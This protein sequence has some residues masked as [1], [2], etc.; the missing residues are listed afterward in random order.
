[1]SLTSGLLCNYNWFALLWSSCT[2]W[3]TLVVSNTAVPDTG[4]TNVSRKEK[5]KS[6][7]KGRRV[8]AARCLA[9]L[10]ACACACVCII[11]HAHA[12]N[13]LRYEMLMNV[14]NVFYSFGRFGCYG[15]MGH[16]YDSIVYYSWLYI[17][18]RYFIEQWRPAQF[19][20]ILI[21]RSNDLGMQFRRNQ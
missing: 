14:D 18:L 13:S 10:C 16:F 12:P 6:I 7:G 11:A 3:N 2:A 5:K 19:T 9:W 4:S 15:L 20:F 1:M 17:T 21:S 8:F